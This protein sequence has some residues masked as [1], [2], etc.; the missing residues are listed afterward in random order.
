MLVSIERDSRIPIYVQVAQQF[1]MLILSGALVPGAHLPTT[2]DLADSL[3][4][5]R[6]TVVDA[7]RILQAEGLV[8]GSGRRGTCVARFDDQPEESGWIRPIAWTRLYSDR[9]VPYFAERMRR[10]LIE[11]PPEDAIPLHH[12]SDSVG[13]MPVQVLRAACDAAVR[14]LDQQGIFEDA[15]V[16][17]TGLRTALARHMRLLGLDAAPSNIMVVSGRQ[18]GLFLAAQTLVSPGDR[19]AVQVPAYSGILH[20]LELL[21]AETCPIVN[22]PEG[23]DLKS[24]MGL[25][26]RG[27]IKLLYLSPNH[28]PIEDPVGNVEVWKEIIQLAARF[29]VPILEDDPFRSLQY[30]GDALPPL[31]SLDQR[32]QTLY[33]GSLEQEVFAGIR[34]GFIVA[35]RSVIDAMTPIKLSLEK[36]TAPFMARVALYLLEHRADYLPA[37]V[38]EGRRRR[39]AMLSALEAHCHPWMT[40]SRPTGGVSVWGRLVVPVSTARLA[41]LACTE[42]RVIVAPGR[43]YFPGMRDGD[44]LLRMDFVGQPVERIAEGIRRLAGVL[45]RYP[46]RWNGTVPTAS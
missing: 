21:G 3:G 45:S 8:E 2:R 29:R 40:W 20:A 35:P 43:I 46:T 24:L 6:K 28:L 37:V 10:Q 39:D 14:E 15:V 5:N 27:D 44:R 19:V 13:L 41:E 22:G 23:P 31:I 11:S 17:C 9:V 7:Y 1:R 16:G 33:V 26:Q 32:H 18:Q 4:V 30:E 38:E 25:L 34:L 36:S 42:G 12:E